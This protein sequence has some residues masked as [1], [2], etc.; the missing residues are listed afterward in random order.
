MERVRAEAEARHASEREAFGRAAV[1]AAG[2]LRRLESAN[3]ALRLQL[4]QMVPSGNGSGQLPRWG[5]G[6]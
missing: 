5:E 3:Y 6:Y 2:H 4:E 1:E